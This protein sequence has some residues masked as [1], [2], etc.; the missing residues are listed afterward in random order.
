MNKNHIVQSRS[1]KK[2]I[3]WISQLI[4]LLSISTLSLTS[5]AL[6]S[7]V[8]EIMFD[9]FSYT[10]LLD[11]QKNGWVPRTDNGHPGIKNAT[12]WAKGI[13]FHVQQGNFN[14]SVMRLTSKTDGSAANSRHTQI[15]HQR[16]YFEGTYAARVY[17]NDKPDFGPDGDGI[18]ETFYTISPLQAPM[19]KNYSEMDFEYL[20]NGGW[21]EKDNVLF[22][23]SW[24]TFQLEPW[25]KVNAFDTYNKSLQGWNILVLQVF[26]NTIKY[27]INGHL[28]SQ[29]GA[30]VYPEV[31]M[32]VNFNLWFIPEQIVESTE[33]RQYHQDV[34]WVYFNA[35]RALSQKE[36]INEVGR[37]RSQ[38][39]AHHDNVPNWQPKLDS[40]C[41]L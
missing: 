10:S 7:K 4:T 8:D 31:A 6:E 23:T 28:F 3:T 18:V 27:Y 5:G 24:E 17:F 39:I 35:D 37:L 1:L 22:S 21:G 14:N 9:D 33:M 19:D 20:A 13:S 34:D 29:H 36:V 25:T 38:E 2:S 12:W 15:C 32:S 26:N 40:Y 16:K 30:D 11:A 41:G